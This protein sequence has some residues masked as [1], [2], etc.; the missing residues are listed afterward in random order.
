MKS[1][2]L[3]LLGLGKDTMLVEET[4]YMNTNTKS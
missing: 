2:K 4:I 3:G 1:V